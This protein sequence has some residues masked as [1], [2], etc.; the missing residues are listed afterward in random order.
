MPVVQASMRWAYL[1][2]DMP[3]PTTTIESH[4]PTKPPLYSVGTLTLDVHES[5]TGLY[6]SFL[7]FVSLIS[8]PAMTWILLPSDAAKAP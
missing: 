3:P 7:V 8:P 4:T 6:T 1:C 2:I 5:V